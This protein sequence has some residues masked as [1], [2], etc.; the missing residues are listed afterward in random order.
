[1]NDPKPRSARDRSRVGVGQGCERRYG[2]QAFG[3]GEELRD[4]GP[5]AGS[6][7]DEVNRAVA[8]GCR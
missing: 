6:S 4:A 7:T 5:R 1:M 2:T 8:A 3:I